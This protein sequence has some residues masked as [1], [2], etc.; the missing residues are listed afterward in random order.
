MTAGPSTISSLLPAWLATRLEAGSPGPPAP[1]ASRS[2]ED[3]AARQ[4][5]FSLVQR[6][7]G[8]PPGQAIEQAE[9]V[10]AVLAEELDP[11]ALAA[12][13]RRL[14]PAVAG[15]LR[16]RRFEGEAP[17]GRRGRRDTLASGRPG[18]RHPLGEASAERRQ[19]HSIADTPAPH[20]D[21][22][23]STGHGS[24]DEPDHTLAGGRAGSDRPLSGDE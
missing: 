19:A 5:F 20:A 14:P 22:K 18:S 23:L 10:L 8:I 21:R 1:P 24:E 12:L 4:R 7:E 13:A 9:T 3:P 11:D 15:L 17:P 6:A 16:P 2:A